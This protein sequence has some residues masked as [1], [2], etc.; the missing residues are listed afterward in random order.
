[1]S[2]RLRLCVPARLRTRLVL[3]PVLAIVASLGFAACSGSSPKTAT[4]T[5]DHKLPAPPSGS[6]ASPTATVVSYLAALSHHDTA[7]AERLIYP[8]VRKAIVAATGSGFADL[9]NLQDVKVLA[10]ATGTQYRPTVSGVSFSKYR[11]FA[12]V[13]VS[14]TATFSSSK[15]PSGPQTKL[16]TVGENAGSKWII[17]AVK[18]SV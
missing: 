9:T 6:N 15:L 17:L 8:K 5:T 12:Q 10:S 7:L 13:K 2:T 14:Y 11:L 18:A 16:M 4:S 1:M 3:L